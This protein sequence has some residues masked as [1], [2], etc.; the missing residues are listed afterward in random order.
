MLLDLTS[1]LKNPEKHRKMYVPDETFPKKKD[2]EK[3]KVG[4]CPKRVFTKF[5]SNWSQWG[6]GGSGVWDPLRLLDHCID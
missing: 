2:V 3:R 1:L 6:A 5:R 4:N